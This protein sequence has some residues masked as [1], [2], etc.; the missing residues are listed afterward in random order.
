MCGIAGIIH[1]GET[2][3]NNSL[4]LDISDTLAHRGPDDSGYFSDKNVSLGFRRLSIVDLESGNQPL[5][6]EAESL[7]LIC[8]GEIFN[9]KEIK[10]ELIEKGHLFRTNSDVEVILHLYEEHGIN[11]LDKL[12]GQFA[13]A[14][15]DIDKNCVFLGRDHVGIAPLFYT[16][17]EGLYYFSSEIKGLLKIP[18]FSPTVNMKGLDQIFTFPSLI[19]PTT[20]FNDVFS[21]KPGHYMLIEPNNVSIKEYWDMNYPMEKDEQIEKSEQSYLEELDIIIEKAVKRRLNADVP[22]GLYLSGGVDSSLIAAYSKKIDPNKARHTF[23]VIFDNYLIDESK[24]QRL[25]SSSINSLHHETAIN[26]NNIVEKL[27]VAVYHSETPLKESYNTCSLALSE[28]ANKNGIKVVLSG[29][30]ADELFGGYVGYKFDQIHRFKKN[31]LLDEDQSLEHELRN[32]LWGDENFYYE[33]DYY[34][35][36]DL[37][38]SIYSVEVNKEFEHFNSIE[39]NVVDKSKISGISNLHKRSYIDLKL[40]MADHLLAGHGDRVGL[41]NAVEMR[42]PFLDIELMEYLKKM[43]SGLKL[44]DLKE[45]YILKKCAQ[46]YVPEEIVRREKFSFVA[47]GSPELLKENIDW[48]NNLLSFE[49]IKRQGYFNPDAIERLKQKYMSPDFNINQTFEFDYLMIVITF[50]I[51][52]EVFNMPNYK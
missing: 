49:T 6:N 33:I 35:H 47:S 3:I 36:Q 43:P 5:F 18:G 4:L 52:L 41:A 8:N 46:K 51:F 32:I 37:K 40:R 42:Y 14:L 21:L 7:V 44:K 26:A 50:G 29:E 12:N 48:I 15:Y 10:Q 23:S 13:F 20:M 9:Y 11:F 16:K 30:G 2:Q 25:V 31:N 27:K 24:Y 39:S 19:S 22:V 28:L 17:H 34:Q 45:K 38:K 1:F